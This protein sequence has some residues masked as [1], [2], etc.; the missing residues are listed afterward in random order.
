MHAVEAASAWEFPTA[1][2]AL[3]IADLLF[4]AVGSGKPATPWE[5]MQR[6]YASAPVG[7]GVEVVL[8]PAIVGELVPQP[9]ASAETAQT[10]MTYAAIRVW[11]RM[12]LGSFHSR[13]GE[14]FG[15]RRTALSV[16]RSGLQHRYLVISL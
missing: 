8:V 15:P 9:A 6:A 11:E 1:R 5:R 12:R 14:W 7:V 2:R 10:A 16:R 13:A 3:T 4:P